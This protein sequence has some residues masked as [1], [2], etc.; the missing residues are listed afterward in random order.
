[1][2]VYGTGRRALH[3]PTLFLPVWLPALSA[4]PKTRGT[5]WFRSPYTIQPTVPSVGGSVTP[6]S[7]GRLHGGLRNLNRMSIRSPFRVPVRSR[8]TLIRLALFRNPW[9]FGARV[10]LA[11]CRYSCLHFLFAPLQHTSRYAFSA[12]ANAPLPIVS[13]RSQVFGAVLDARSSSTRHRST[14]ELL[15]TL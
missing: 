11:R 5:V 14:S 12:G 2:S 3:A 9:A 10:S 15:R 7:R 4:R 6:G 1:M 8:L 13:L